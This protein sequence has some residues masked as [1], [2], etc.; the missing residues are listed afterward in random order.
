M[1]NEPVT[2]FTKKLNS[3][4]KS[5][6]L[7]VFLVGM[8]GVGKTTIGRQLALSLERDFIDLDHAIEQ[9]SGVPIATIFDIEGE[10]GFRKRES[11]L[12]DEYTQQDSIVLATGGGAILSGENRQILRQR[13]CV[14]YLRAE[15]DILFNRLARDSKRPLLQTANPQQRIRE[16]IMQREPLYASVADIT[17][18]TGNKPIPAI[19]QE[20]T[21]LLQKPISEFSE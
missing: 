19:L 12:L 15:L 13:G 8:M 14:I 18:D 17:F 4:T 21:E 10:F 6:D 9:R 3:A 11:N 5:I 2:T 7:P 16:L 1:P 20:L